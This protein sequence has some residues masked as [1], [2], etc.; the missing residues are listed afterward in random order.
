[1]RCGANVVRSRVRS[2]ARGRGPGPGRDFDLP[3]PDTPRLAT[4]QGLSL[5]CFNTPVHNTMSGGE[6]LTL[7]T[8]RR[9]LPLALLLRG[10][11]YGVLTQCRG[12]ILT[13]PDTPTTQG[14]SLWCFNTVP[15]PWPR[16][17]QA[18]LAHWGALP[19]SA[20]QHTHTHA[21]LHLTLTVYVQRG[22]V[23]LTVLCHAGTAAHM[24]V[25]VRLPRRPGRTI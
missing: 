15:R 10:Y 16:S 17:A 5:W 2:H 11:L 6:I 24:V 19:H 7:R 23:H 25:A 20:E 1:M 8:F 21:T 22:T 9:H 13:F 4:T 12:E 3:R 18:P 14:L